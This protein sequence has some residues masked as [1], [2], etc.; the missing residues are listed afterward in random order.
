MLDR[1]AQQVHA[2]EGRDHRQRQR[3]GRHDGRAPVAQEQPDHQHR[4]DRAFVQQVHRGVVFLGRDLHEVQRARE[5][6]VRVVGLAAG[7][8]RPRRRRPPRLRWRRGCARPPKPTTRLP[9]S[10]AAARCSATVS[11]MRAMVS[12]RTRRRARQRDLHLAQRV[13][14]GHGADG[15]DRLF[16]ASEVGAA[17]GTLL[18]HQPQLARHV[19]RRGP[20]RLQARRVQR[21]AQPRVRRRPRG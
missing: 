15:A 10:S 14:R 5:A 8:A 9:F 2:D 7:A 4:Q 17:A 20:Q 3:H 11:S 18:L 6:D 16:Q 21:H 12:S 13:G 19:G 1:E